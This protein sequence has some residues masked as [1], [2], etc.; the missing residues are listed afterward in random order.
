MKPNTISYE[1]AKKLIRVDRV[2][3]RGVSAGGRASSRWPDFSGTFPGW[4]V[5]GARSFAWTALVT[6]AWCVILIGI[7]VILTGISRTI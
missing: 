2:C 5:E 3:R 4:S 1:A 7:I 6:I